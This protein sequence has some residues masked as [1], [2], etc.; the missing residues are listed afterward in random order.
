MSKKKFCWKRTVSVLLA[1]AMLITAAPQTGMSVYATGGGNVDDLLSADDVTAQETAGDENDGDLSG[2]E[3]TTAPGG[4]DESENVG[5][6]TG[7][8]ENP[9]VP[10]DPEKPDLSDDA[11]QP[12]DGGEAGDSEDEAEPGESG[13][14]LTADEESVSMNDIGADIMSAD[15]P[16]AALEKPAYVGEI[17]DKGSRLVVDEN[18]AKA[19]GIDNLWEVLNYYCDEGI[20]QKFDCVQ[21]EVYVDGEISASNPNIKINGNYYNGA[22]RIMNYEAE[23]YWIDYNFNLPDGLSMGYSLHYPTAIERNDAELPVGCTLTPVK[24]QGM[25]INMATTDFPVGESGGVSLYWNKGGE[26]YDISDCFWVGAD[27]PHTVLMTMSGDAPSQ[28]VPPVFKLDYEVDHKN[29]QSHI[30]FN[31]SGAVKAPA[32]QFEA[33]KDYLIT[34]MCNVSY[35]LYKDTELRAGSRSGAWDD[36]ENVTWKILNEYSEQ[37]YTIQQNEE[38]E[39]IATLSTLRYGDGEYYSVSYTVGGE[40]YFELYNVWINAVTESGKVLNYL[41]DIDNS[42]TI[43][44]QPYSRLV[45]EEDKAQENSGK[46][47][48]EKITS[49][50]GWYKEQGQ[51]FNC[52]EFRLFDSS[53][54]TIQKDYVNGAIDILE[55]IDDDHL[56]WVDFAFWNTESEVRFTLG[57]PYKT[58]AN[59]KATF[60]LTE[61]ANQ[62]LKLKFATTAFP[63]RWVDF[64]Y[65]QQGEK[66][67]TSLPFNNA[68]LRLFKHSS[69]NPTAIVAKE[70]WQQFRYE[71]SDEGNEK[72]TRLHFDNILSLGTTEYLVTSLYWDE[73]NEENGGNPVVGVAKELMAGDRAGNKVKAS[74]LG[75][76][77]Y[78]SV[79]WKALDADRATIDNNG[80][81]TAWSNQG[82]IY[83]YV[84]YKSGSNTYLEV[85]ETWAS[86]QP[87]KITLDQ[88]KLTLNYRADGNSEEEWLKVRYYPVGVDRN[89]SRIK[90]EIEGGSD[91]ISLIQVKDD[92]DNPK[93]DKEGKPVY[94]GGIRAEKP[95]TATVKVSYLAGDYNNDQFVPEGGALATATCE[96]TVVQQYTWDE[97]AHESINGKSIDDLYAI[98]GIDETLAAIEL[99]YDDD[100]DTGWTWDEPNTSL[101]SFKGS[102]GHPF[103]ATYTFNG[104]KQFSGHV[105]VAFV[106]PMGITLTMKNTNEERQDD[107]PEWYEG[108]PSSMWAGD[109]LNEESGEYDNAEQ[110]TLSYQYVLDGAGIWDDDGGARY[111]DAI[112]RLEEYEKANY[113]VEW[114]S[115]P[116][117]ALEEV[118]AGKIYQ[119]TASIV[120]KT[121]KAEKK[122]FTVTVKNAKNKAVYKASANVTV[123]VSPNYDFDGAAFENGDQLY[124]TK[125]SSNQMWLVVKVNNTTVED[126]S[127]KKL[128][129]ASEDTA[130]LKLTANKTVINNIK[131]VENSGK[132]TEEEQEQTEDNTVYV[133][134]PCTNPKPGTA[135]IKITAP[136]EMKNFRRYQIDFPDK[137]PKAVSATT[138][139][140]NRAMTAENRTATVTVRT[141]AKY[142]LEFTA[143]EEGS[144]IDYLLN[145]KASESLVIRG[146]QTGNVEIDNNENDNNQ[147]NIYDIVVSLPDKDDPGIKNGKSTV[148]LNLKVKP[149]EQEEPEELTY[150]LKLTV[151]V[152]DTVPKVTFKQ[153]KKVNLF[154]NDDE[155][156]GVLTVTVAGGAEIDSGS[157][158]L[159]DYKDAKKPANDADCS[160]TLRPTG[161]NQYDIIWEDDNSVGQDGVVKRDAK[162]N[163]GILRYRLKGY[164]G[165]F[166]ANLT[167]STET[168]KPTI[169]LSAKSDTLYPKVYYT[170]S[171]IQLTDKATGWN[172]DPS[173]VRYVVNAKKGEYIDLNVA[174]V[175]WDNY[176]SHTGEKR[177]DLNNSYYLIMTPWG[178]ITNRLVE[179][180]DLKSYK[181]KAD[182][183]T[184]EVKEANWTDYI[185]VPY[186]LT[187]STSDPK[188]VLGK[189]TL[190]LN[191]HDDV[192]QSQQE[193]TTLRLKGH[194][195]QIQWD[196]W[197]FV[198]FVGQDDKSKKV[199]SIDGS[200]VLD[201]WSNPG[202]VLVSFND[203]NLA[204]GTYKFKISVGIPAQG[205]AYASTTLTVKVVDTPVSKNLKVT[206]KGSIDLMNIDGTSITYTPKLS[207]LSGQVNGGWLEGKDEDMFESWWDGS[208]LVVQARWG[209]SYSTKVNYQVYPVFS[210]NVQDYNGYIV[211][212]DKALNIKVKQGKPKLTA[213]MSSNTIYRQ[214]DNDVEIKLSAIL[215]KKDVEIDSVWL[216]NYWEDFELQP[217][218]TWHNDDTGEDYPLIYNPETQSVRLKLKDRYNTDNVSVV[219][220]G[221]TWKVKLQVRYANKAENEKVAEVT[222]SI[223]V[224]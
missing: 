144:N 70:E 149:T 48:S 216:A 120:G 203:N 197:N 3:T 179:Q 128:T 95:G 116:K 103:A 13:D 98:L 192:Y 49:I 56:G 217:N 139:A 122:T 162:K 28:V 18:D 133:K 187:V 193:R 140:I 94:D 36:V 107:E 32:N 176:D 99:P 115:T 74:E 196:E 129:I 33:K 9:E 127:K 168:K 16:M 67:N 88:E 25:K 211:R 161:D 194:T 173:E 54:R 136:D 178:Q 35:P 159:D 113:T 79:T 29:K 2:D 208:K 60:T 109:A 175:D 14:E 77:G 119:Y 164:D 22:V 97:K 207:N 188:L 53:S 91:A 131:S 43:D 80:N 209:N 155:G 189:S 213:A 78:T 134:I 150:Q 12:D 44:E 135:W 40:Q 158:C 160:Y 82:Q 174:A 11:D 71:V 202:D 132:G 64:D 73:W 200:L 206:A 75:A 90:W 108:V 21:I 105:W 52:I 87:V 151:N 170:N 41:G 110:V 89:E 72:N 138:V 63:A 204:T 184:L 147:Y 141:N 223:V 92:E 27:E 117:D 215:G 214:L 181:T 221:K 5:G 47:N 111:Q 153:T 224:R 66:Y 102:Y 118:E 31:V 106:T 4:T 130:V 58:T 86:E 24:N 42:D 167:V 45:I 15:E 156:N 84:K 76:N 10:E 55:D 39:R 81:M 1:M 124:V 199:L 68:D 93:T 51:T 114:T 26:N 190:T 157:L 62:G 186:S 145:D 185:S 142:P 100:T 195:N 198:T 7:K 30:V 34:S 83:Y 126:Y 112:K 125:D 154:Y 46:N 61:L 37:F 65:N 85:H 163:K 23:E 191:K 222:C 172:I 212:P 123:T 218:G 101:A 220:S 38:D 146:N 165:E 152:S 20:D 148:T 183:I 69:G 169:V 210:V 121:R 6:G 166:Q 182:K 201:Y 180:D 8:T 171:F 104:V 17:Q 96:V 177:V 143:G 59:V 50:L 219:Q 137:E 205:T 57:A 19:A